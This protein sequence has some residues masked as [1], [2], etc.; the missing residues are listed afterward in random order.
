MSLHP[1]LTMTYRYTFINT[2]HIL[3]ITLDIFLTAKNRLSLK[4]NIT[5]QKNFRTVNIALC[6][7]S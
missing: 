1:N 2:F 6:F 7:V 5:K 4:I 3:G